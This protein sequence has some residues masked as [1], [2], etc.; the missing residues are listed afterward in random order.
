[1]DKIA[2][3]IAVVAAAKAERKREDEAQARRREEQRQRREQE[4]RF[5]YIKERRDGELSKLLDAYLRLDRLES[6]LARACD[7]PEGNEES[8]VQ[9]FRHWLNGQISEIQA[10][11]TPSGLEQRFSDL[12]L[13]GVEDDRDFKPARW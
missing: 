2:V 12:N 1:M 6:L 9:E 10:L 4:A 5:K 13:F 3:G 8:R 7:G 11:L